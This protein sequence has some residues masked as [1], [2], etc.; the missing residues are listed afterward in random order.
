MKKSRLVLIVCA[1]MCV[2]LSG[3]VMAIAF[4]Q[5]PVHKHS[6]SDARVYHVYSDHVYY[7]RQCKKDGHEQ[8]F[9]MNY[10]VSFVDVLSSLGSNDKILLE[11]NVVVNSEITLKSYKSEGF[12]IP[13]GIELNINIDLNGKTLSVGHVLTKQNNALFMF[14]SAKGVTNFNIR[15][16][17][18][19]SSELSYIFKFRT[20][21]EG[22]IN[23][24]LNNVECETIG[25]KS[26]PIYLN[27]S[28]V[29]LNAIDSGFTSTTTSVNRGDFG[30]GVFINTNNTAT[31]NNCYFEGGDA[32]YVRSGKVYLTD[33]V[34]QNNGLMAGTVQG[35]RDDDSF[36]AIGSCLAAESYTSNTAT[37]KFEIV[38]NGCQ[39]LTT[40]NGIGNSNR[41]IYVLKT[42]LSGNSTAINS[43]S[44]IDIQ[45]CVFD[46][47]PAEGDDYGVVIY[48]NN[49]IPEVN[50]NGLWVCG[51]LS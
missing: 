48:P 19:R 35:V 5:P 45:S 13:Q 17:A 28:N 38:I 8:R 26:T 12:I 23:L 4:W 49:I 31:F 37:S 46:Q 47:N 10:N 18:I 29:K 14:D 25:A 39:M 7:T 32:V 42:A 16:G 1:C 33:C 11:E 15:N 27:G 34:L 41:A 51:D 36:D 9:N 22:A 20:T 43:G 3:I 6:L 24:N 40:S 21:D 30:V 2:V 50:Q 44:Y